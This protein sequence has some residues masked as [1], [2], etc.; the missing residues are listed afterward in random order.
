MFIQNLFIYPIKS[1]GG[2]EVKSFS[3]SQIGPDL[4][5]QFVLVDEQG[6]FLSQRTLPKMAQISVSVMSFP[7][8]TVGISA[9]G[10][11]CHRI[12]I[13]QNDGPV[14]DITI[15][16][17]SCQ[18]I[19][20][21]G[22]HAQ[23]FS[24]FLGQQCRLVKQLPRTP[25]L[26]TP[27]ALG[28]EIKVSY[29]DG[30]PL[31]VTSAESLDNLNTRITANG[32]SAVPMNRFRPNIVLSGCGE[33]Y[34]EDSWRGLATGLVRLEAANKCVR[35]IITTTDQQTGV[36]EKEPLR[37]LVTYRKS[38]SGIEFGRNFTVLVEGRVSV[39]DL[40]VSL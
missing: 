26:R 34:S 15:H 14:M 40:V 25:R 31:L 12:S 23:W 29:A 22:Y 3:L 33:A 9:P 10:M 16:K 11:P 28:R 35:C 37:T 7:A 4:D 18:G 2:I 27:S 32:G 19:D 20:L 13:Q 6:K 39:G 1:C 21:G 17:D 8:P 24:E 36:R 5:R 30:Y 38:E